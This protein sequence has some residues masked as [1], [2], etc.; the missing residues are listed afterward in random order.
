MDLLDADGTCGASVDD[1]L[2]VLDRNK[3]ALVIK[4]GPIAL[5]EA[6]HLIVNCAIKVR[7]V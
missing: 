7:K 5:D 3:L 6:I 2:V 1:T 4:D